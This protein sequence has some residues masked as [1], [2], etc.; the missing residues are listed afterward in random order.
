MDVALREG[1]AD[2]FLV[3]ALLDRLLNI[4]IKAPLVLFLNPGAHGEVNRAVA[5]LG[6]YYHRLSI[7]EHTFVRLYYLHQNIM[8][9]VEIVG[10][11]DT[12]G[13]VTTP[14]IIGRNVR[15]VA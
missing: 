12:K 13:Q 9:L 4:G 15:D 5:Q 8:D 2:P 11:T 3:E 1:D 14:R 7:F 10:V 6:H